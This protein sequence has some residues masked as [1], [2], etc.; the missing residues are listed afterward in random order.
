MSPSD[1]TPS[2]P[3]PNSYWVLPRQLLAG[4][5]PGG[6]D[7]GATRERIAA[8]LAAGVDCF[9]DLTAA[10]ELPPY[11]KALPASILYF[12]R[13][14]PDHGL[15]AQRE[16]MRDIVR[17]VSGQLE[18]GRRVYV[19]C[20]AGIG[21][22]GTVIGCLLAERGF[23]GQAALE[24]LNRLWRQS[25][26]SQTWRYVPETLDQADYVCQW[27]A[28]RG[29]RVPAGAAS[30]TPQPA[31]D[32]RQRF[33]GALAGLATGDALA[34]PTQ[35][36]SSGAFARVTDMLGG[37]KLAL[38]RGAWSDDTAMALCLAESLLECSGS[39]TRDQLERYSRWQREGY[40]SST[41]RCVGIRASTARALA[42][43]QW[44]RQSFAGSHDPKQ[45]DPEPLARIAPVAMYAFASADEAV[46]LAG[47]AAR[48]TCQAPVVVEACRVFAAM[49]HAAL[50]GLPKEQVLAPQAGLAELAASGFKPR[51]RSLLA[52]RYRTQSPPQIRAGSTVVEALEAALWAFARTNAFSDGALLAVNLG[53][54]SD[55]VGA[56]YGQ[57]AGAFYGE[58]GI[59]APWR[60]S[61]VR[62][63]LIMSLSDRLTA[64]AQ[65][66]N[67]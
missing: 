57:L 13:P 28:E 38:P 50:K 43:A 46:S 14:I 36:E 66:R 59:P 31:L 42:A 26:R 67:S 2:L 8:L 35:G 33:L 16:Q 18:A 21:R 41:G 49:I 12:Q 11:H 51:I 44:R 48:T 3:L 65:A 58:A 29:A 5:Y 52:G 24:E 19:H 54:S 64:H 20:R 45:L 17:F 40:M 53:E 47:E 32:L 39:D 63:D 56:A 15:P 62:L 30:G 9:I 27:R 34:A 6:A 10:D 7:A 61:L 23:A 22:T 25:P 37:G 1:A 55:V 60:A 4:E